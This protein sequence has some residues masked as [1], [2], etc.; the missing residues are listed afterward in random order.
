MLSDYRAALTKAGVVPSSF[1]SKTN[2]TLTEKELDEK[3]DAGLPIQRVLQKKILAALNSPMSLDDLLT[4]IPNMSK[5][6]WIPIIFNLMSRGLITISG[7][8]SLVDELSFV[9]FGSLPDLISDAYR[10]LLQPES[11][12]FGYSMFLVFAERELSRVGQGMCSIAYLEMDARGRQISREALW[13][14]SVCFEAVRQPLD[15]LAY[16][17]PNQ[18]F[19]LMPQTALMEGQRRI[20]EFI[21]VISRNALDRNLQGHELTVTY[22]LAGTPDDRPDLVTLLQ[23]AHR[24]WRKSTQAE[25]PIIGPLSA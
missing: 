20:A 22:G 11:G 3:L 2:P 21:D 16:S 8:K 14:I 7:T 25:T 15:I 18:L 9:S 6:V 13:E 10:S 1:L 12:M 24:H 23:V 17:V 4:A 5:S 19:I